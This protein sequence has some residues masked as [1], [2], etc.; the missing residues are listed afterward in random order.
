MWDSA[1]ACHGVVAMHRAFATAVCACA[2]LRAVADAFS[3]VTYPPTAYFDPTSARVYTQRFVDATCSYTDWAP[4]AAPQTFSVQSSDGATTWDV[5]LVCQAPEYVYD[6]TTVGYI[7]RSGRLYISEFCRAL[8]ASARAI[9]TPYS[10]AVG[11][12]SIPGPAARR[13]LGLFGALGDVF[14]EIVCL[15]P[16][17]NDALERYAGNPCGPS[18]PDAETLKR[19]EAIEK[20]I[21]N[22]GKALESATASLLGNITNVTR[23]LG[24]A[25]E[26]NTWSIGNVSALAQTN[27]ENINAVWNRTDSLRQ[28]IDAM[29][30]TTRR[31]MEQ[32]RRWH[33]QALDAIA[34]TNVILEALIGEVSEQQQAAYYNLRNT[35]A[36][37]A[38]GLNE[39]ADRVT[40]NRIDAYKEFVLNAITA[41]SLAGLLM[42]ATTRRPERRVFTRAAIR[43]AEAAVN[44]G[45]TPFL[46]TPGASATITSEGY[47]PPLERITVRTLFGGA[48]W[49]DEFLFACSAR[50]LSDVLVGWQSS[51]DLLN[52]L[53]PQNCSTT[54][55]DGSACHCF[56]LYTQRRCVAH[57]S[58]GDDAQAE[59]YARET[60]AWRTQRA[61]NVTSMCAFGNAIETLEE[62]PLYLADEYAA[63]IAAI[64]SHSADIGPV[65]YVLRTEFTGLTLAL[66][67]RESLENTTSFTI[68]KSADAFEL[69]RAMTSLLGI[70]QG[71]YAALSDT[72]TR[73][74]DGVIPDGV[75]FYDYPFSSIGNTSAACSQ[76]MM[77]AYEPEWIPQQRALLREVRVSMTATITNR[78]AP[79]VVLTVPIREIAYSNALQSQLP[80]DF[81]TAGSPFPDSEL[82]IYDVE[83]RGLSASP[84][85]QAR[86]GTVSYAL[87]PYGPGGCTWSDFYNL[88]GG[89]RFDAR[90][91]A[92]VADLY[93]RTLVRESGAWRC[94][95]GG[96]PAGP[97]SACD[98][99]ARYDVYP[100]DALNHTLV[101]RPRTHGSLV[102]RFAIP[103]GDIT[104]LIVSDCPTISVER[105]TADGVM[106]RLTNA[107]PQALDLTLS[108]GGACCVG[109][110]PR[111]VTVS[112]GGFAEVWVP[113]CAGV[114][115]GACTAPGCNTLSMSATQTLSGAPCANIQAIDVTPPTRADAIA[116]RGLP[117]LRHVRQE[118]VTAV[119]ALAA[120]IATVVTQLTASIGDLAV[121]QAYQASQLGVIDTPD[122][123][124]AS[125]FDEIIARLRNVTAAVNRT[126][127]EVEAA[128]YSEYDTQREYYNA[129]MDDQDIT[130]QRLAN[131]SQSRI[132]ILANLSSLQQSNLLAIQES[133]A[134]LNASAEEFKVAQSAYINAT[135]QGFK[136]IT[137]LFRSIR[138]AQGGGGLDF[139]FDELDN[140]FGDL[141]DL[142]GDVAE[143]FVDLVGDGV[144]LPFQ[145][146][147]KLLGFLP[148]LTGSLITYLSLAMCIFSVG[149]VIYLYKKV[150]K[151][152]EHLMWGGAHGSSGSGS[153]DG[154]KTKKAPHKD[155]EKKPLVKRHKSAKRGDA[156]TM[157]TPTMS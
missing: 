31:N 132:A 121:R 95:P 4:G 37:L 133:Q 1:L 14:E 136:T 41:R 109:V 141:L 149:G 100:G 108:F 63:T 143:K 66:P 54:A 89:Q 83:Q 59:H 135:L 2:L 34:E 110:A 118:R 119:D 90:S 20:D 124:L 103:T 79:E 127:S 22:T 21:E 154:K 58:L 150:K 156:S 60:S 23:V 28:R 138:N 33:L 48:A 5:E 111:A 15:T 25:I 26:V 123:P 116:V 82:R 131:E 12:A 11:R 47:N 147:D 87:C 13:L 129:I 148:G 29:G 30:T 134:A 32:S 70:S 73:A 6:L 18:F 43:F 57:P 93:T 50:F 36:R 80:G 39:L 51:T 145:A 126:R 53:G 61:L 74:I 139:G 65:T 114:C 10:A 16:V 140:V 64:A 24:Y 142:G 155:P 49:E 137:Q 104:Q 84:D 55:D 91:G 35:T 97:S 45:L 8:D 81:L 88:T 117:D 62:R 122:F 85:A 102:A 76:V 152:E 92:N 38:D 42:S 86:A 101:A 67:W 146:L 96:D 44:E 120:A 52:A 106:V 153:G 99:R 19:L 105:L 78:D 94:A 75:S 40:E 17:V 7:P 112:G 71:E 72:I 9:A 130:R 46:R 69:G 77:M 144:S 3:L 68:Q 115:G 157:E 113:S 56:V 98:M 151:L 27:T 125:G 107:R 128:D